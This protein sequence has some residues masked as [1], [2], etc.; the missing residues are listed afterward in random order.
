M[1][2]EL[3]FTI[4]RVVSDVLYGA[5]HFRTDQDTVRDNV[6]RVKV[7]ISRLFRSQVRMLRTCAP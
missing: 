2:E 7:C 5:L 6:C 3:T 4:A 1:D